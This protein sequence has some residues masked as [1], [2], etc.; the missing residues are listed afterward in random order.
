MYIGIQWIHFRGFQISWIEKN[1]SW[2]SDFVVLLMYVY[3]KIEDTQLVEHLNITK[4][5]KISN[6]RILMNPQ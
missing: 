4:S 6:T 2:I 3:N 1:N 5:T